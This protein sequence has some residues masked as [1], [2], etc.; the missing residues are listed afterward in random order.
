ME[1][2]I[3]SSKKCTDCKQKLPAEAFPAQSK[4]CSTCRY[5]ARRKAASAT[6]QNFLTRSFGQLKHARMKKEKSKKGWEI[7]LEDVLELWELQ[8]GRCALT[9]LFMTFHKDGSG[10]RDLNV[11]I[12]RK[13]PI[14][15]AEAGIT[16]KGDGL[17]KVD[18]R[19][20]TYQY[21]D[22][23]DTVDVVTMFKVTDHQ[24][25]YDFG[26]V[27]FQVVGISNDIF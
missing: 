3:S 26:T 15:A 17:I 6:P 14:T 8:K 21:L 9:G 18:T 20:D 13:D 25:L 5:T 7:T 11:S 4:K 2:K 23:S 16:V 19:V 12:D 22:D 24:G 1:K 27:T 10:R